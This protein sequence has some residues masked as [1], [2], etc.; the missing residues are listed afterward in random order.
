M[1]KLSLILAILSLPIG[2]FF[3]VA[4]LTGST[5]LKFVM[6]FEGISVSVL[7][8]LVILKYLNLL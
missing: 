7:S 4:K 3:S 8:I 5:L 6:R 2:L 1:T